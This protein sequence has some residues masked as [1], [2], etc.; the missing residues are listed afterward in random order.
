MAD[1]ASATTESKAFR[2]EGQQEETDEVP[3]LLGEREWIVVGP[4]AS[5]SRW[6]IGMKKKRI[7]TKLKKYI[8]TKRIVIRPVA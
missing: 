8:P 5:G 2:V 6:H 1:M 3:D 4:A 7:K